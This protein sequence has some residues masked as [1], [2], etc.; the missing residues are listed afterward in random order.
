MVYVILSLVIG[1]AT[2]DGWL[3]LMSQIAIAAIEILKRR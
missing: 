3:G 1:L 2:I